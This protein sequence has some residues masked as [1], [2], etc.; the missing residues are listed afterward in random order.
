M[1][2]CC[3]QCCCCCQVAASV[4]VAAG[5]LP[6]FSSVAKSSQFISLSLSYYQFHP[7]RLFIKL[8]I[9]FYLLAPFLP[10]IPSLPPPSPPLLQPAPIRPP[11]WVGLKINIIIRHFFFL[12]L[13]SFLSFSLSLFLP[14]FL[15][16]FLS[17]G[18]FSFCCGVA[19]FAILGVASVYF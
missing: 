3:F 15:S 5:C 4:A 10:P 7:P 12:S 2:C 11:F 16:F 8:S 1:F 19:L 13:S 9:Y 17:S 14:F 6:G 18:V